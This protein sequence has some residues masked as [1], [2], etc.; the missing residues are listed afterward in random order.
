MRLFGKPL[1]CW[2]SR[3]VYGTLTLSGHLFQDVVGLANRTNG[4]LQF[5]IHPA[6][7]VIQRLG[8]CLVTR[9]YQGNHSC[10][11]FLRLLICLNS[12]GSL[13]QSQLLSVP[14]LVLASYTG[15][16]A[17]HR[18]TFKC[19]VFCTIH[20]VRDLT[21]GATIGKRSQVSLMASVAVCYRASDL[22]QMRSFQKGTSDRFTH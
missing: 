18:E 8:S 15:P 21:A 3:A 1:P 17:Y 12:A 11:L 2:S 9:C 22:P 16:P 19:N 10:F 7:L 5:T 13:M 20:L 14:A 6:L 4:C